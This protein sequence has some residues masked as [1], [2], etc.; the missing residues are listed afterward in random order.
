MRGK[1]SVDGHVPYE[2]ILMG[3]IM[4]D[5]GPQPGQLSQLFR[6]TDARS[7]A[8]YQKSNIP[9]YLCRAHI[10]VLGPSVL[11]KARYGLVMGVVVQDRR[12]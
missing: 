2:R 8:A 4:M 7:V 12:S 10:A 1:S 5:N 6:A 11:Q 3:F 9:D